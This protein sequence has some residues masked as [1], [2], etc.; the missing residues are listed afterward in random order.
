MPK[1]DRIPYMHRK[2][3]GSWKYQRRVPQDAQ[4]ML[5]RD[6]WDLSLGSN[7]VKAVDKARALAREHDD[8]IG[9]ATNPEGTQAR[10]KQELFNDWFDKELVERA[11]EREQRDDNYSYAKR[12][13]WRATE[14]RLQD[15]DA[16]HLMVFAHVA[17]GEPLRAEV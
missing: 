4:E 9:L 6:K 8:A 16:E 11:F 3:D 14:Q 13:H 7:Y 17:F 1:P 10:A 15:L 2:P 5:C 12:W